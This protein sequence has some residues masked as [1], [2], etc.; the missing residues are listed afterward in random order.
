MTDYVESFCSAKNIQVESEI[1]AEIPKFSKISNLSGRI[2][3]KCVEK[4]FSRI[5]PFDAMAQ[6]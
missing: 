2:L 1:L 3:L 6:P 4:C 5:F